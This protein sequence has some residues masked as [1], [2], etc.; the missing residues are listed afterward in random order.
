MRI[1]WPSWSIFV[2]VSWVHLSGLENYLRT[3]NWWWL[4]GYHWPSN[5][6]LRRQHLRHAQVLTPHVN[7][8]GPLQLRDLIE[9]PRSDSNRSIGPTKFSFAEM[10]SLGNSASDCTVLLVIAASYPDRMHKKRSLLFAQQL[11]LIFPLLAG[12][13]GFW[14]LPQSSRWGF[15]K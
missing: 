5:L 12:S 8:F 15:P 7:H 2:G 6:S 4:T 14:S 9:G 3:G 13:P 11:R 1:F 10:M